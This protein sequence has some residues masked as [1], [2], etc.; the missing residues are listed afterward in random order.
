MTLHATREDGKITIHGNTGVSL[1][2]KDSRV[3]TLGITE[4]AQHVRQ[5]WSRLGRLLAEHEGVT[6]GQYLY[7]RYT[8]HTNGKSLMSGDQLPSWAENE[9]KYRAA[10]EHTAA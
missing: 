7:E 8:D 9:D 2:L 4:D 6:P 3:W 1:E 10:W 5:F